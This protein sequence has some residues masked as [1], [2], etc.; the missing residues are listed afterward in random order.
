[1]LDTAEF[2][3]AVTDFPLHPGV[4]RDYETF[5]GF[6]VKHLGHVPVEGESFHYHGYLV[7][8]ID[9]DAHRVDKVLL[10]PLKNLPGAITG[11]KQ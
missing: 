8:I 2:E 4:E 10:F 11:P 5:A 9:L 6:I 7:E 1:M 3:R